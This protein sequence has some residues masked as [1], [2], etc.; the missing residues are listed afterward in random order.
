[1][2]TH[3]IRNAN[4][5]WINTDVFREE[6]LHFKKYGYYCSDR[7]GTYGW[8]QYWDEQLNRCINGYSV[9]GAMITGHHYFYLNFTQMEL[10]SFNENNRKVVDKE[11]SFPHFWD[12]DYNFFWA[13]EVAKR[14]VLNIETTTPEEIVIYNSL[15]SD[16]VLDKLSE[17]RA[18]FLLQLY[19]KLQ[20]EVSTSP[21]FLDGGYHILVGKSRRKGYSYKNAAIVANTYNSVRNSTSIIG[22]FDKK[23]LYPQGTMTMA[24]N[25]IN[26]LNQHTG[27]AKKRDFVDKVDA[28][29]AS[30]ERTNELGFKYEAGYKSMVLALTFADNPDTARGKDAKEVLLEE[31]G[32]FPNLQASVMATDDTLRAGKYLTGQMTIYG[33]SGDIDGDSLD[34]ANLFY[35]PKPFNIF[36][37]YNIWDK[38][39]STT[40]CAYF[41]P[42]NWNMEGFYD[43]QGNSDLGAAKKRELNHRAM[44]IKEGGSSTALQQRLQE[45]PLSPSEAFLNI[46]INNFPVEELRLHL[47]KVKR[48]GLQTKLGQ[49]GYMV[50]ENGK[51]T[52]K[53]DL[54]N[55]LEPLHHYKNNTPNI[56]GCVIVY[57]APLPNAVKGNYKIGYDPYRQEIAKDS[58]SLGA[59]YVYKTVVQG[60][61]NH[62]IIAA[63]YIGRPREMDAYNRNVMLLAEWYKGAE[64]MFENEVTSVKA[65]FEKNKKLNLLAAQPDNLISNIIKSSHVERVYGMHMVE[66]IKEAGEKYINSWLLTVR[67]ITT[68]GR[69]ILQLE[70]INSIGLLEELILYNR[71]GNFDRVIALMFVL[72][73]VEAESICNISEQRKKYIENMKNDLEK[74][75]LILFN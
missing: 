28:K 19:G 10:V 68:D 50:V 25:T 51:A 54:S 36:P 61:I 31:G 24:T 44:M 71:K 12:G 4:G 13:K 48:E 45:N 3:S 74:L 53:P 47:N 75:N 2:I 66:K 73:Q 26:F 69:E 46:S 37:L 38:D 21:D 18:N 56:S 14:G 29:R 20:L 43:K 15:P 59:T 34:I 62:N 30:F 9:G 60:G 16:D 6:A 27:W 23:Y 55:R 8:Q 41:H 22:A 70:T 35:N 67:E 17:E 39:A 58:T 11:Q 72:F 52:F 5:Y 63:E 7:W 33:T 1:M 32:K 57:E 49:P 65:F 40:M 64:V 42:V